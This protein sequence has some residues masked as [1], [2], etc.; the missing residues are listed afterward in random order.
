MSVTSAQGWVLLALFVLFGVAVLCA[1]GFFL[2]KRK[3]IVRWIEA[4]TT[5]RE[6]MLA[7]KIGHSI[8][9][10]VARFATSPEGQARFQQ[11]CDLLTMVLRGYGISLS[12][13]TIEEIIQE[14][15]AV[16]KAT[17]VIAA[18]EGVHPAPPAPS[19]G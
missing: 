3:S 14:A 15:Y 19:G 6:R 8:V 7:E 2:S 1:I 18:S 12:I 10:W 17:G 11:A 5:L 9:V 16:L 13:G 4:H